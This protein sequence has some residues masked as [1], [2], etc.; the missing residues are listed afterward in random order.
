MSEDLETA[1]F[2]SAVKKAAEDQVLRE[3]RNE[4]Q[5]TVGGELQ[6]MEV[7]LL[8][9]NFRGAA[10]LSRNDERNLLDQVPPAAEELH[11]TPLIEV[12]GRQGEVCRLDNGKDY[13]VDKICRSGWWC[14]GGSFSSGVQ[15]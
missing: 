15:V 12:M 14:N 3:M 10:A 7:F 8:E 13:P 6:K 1:R 11:Y 5:K 2:H 4:F 9:D